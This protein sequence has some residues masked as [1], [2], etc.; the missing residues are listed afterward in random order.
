[1]IRIALDGMGGDHAPQAT[2]EGAIDASRELGTHISLVG[3][4]HILESELSRYKYNKR[5]IE[6]VPAS[7][8]I[9]MGESP[10]VVRKKKNSSINVGI[11][12]VKQ[13]KVDAFVSCG[14][15]GAVVAAAIL[16]LKSLS[17]VKRPAIATA[18][19][20]MKGMTLVIDV[21]A[22]VDPKPEH[23][24][25]Y[26]LMG[27]VYSKYILK[28]FRPTV[29]L[30]NIGE[31]ASKGNE[32]I[33][34]A[35]QLL[36]DAPINFSGNIEGRDI[37][38][39]RADVIICDGFVGNIVLKV[40]ESLAETSVEFFRREFRRSW[41]A[42][43]GALLCKPALLSLAREIDYTEFGGAPLLG[44]DGTCIIGHGASKPK[45]IKNAIRV[46]GHFVDHKVNDHIVNEL[47]NLKGETEVAEFK[48]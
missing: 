16:N 48:A 25:Q 42:R 13:K 15:T 30:L 34:E 18:L 28:K 35:Y 27:T 33:R 3:Q 11:D 12:L 47:S 44:I 6:I 2:I 43:I 26:A 1:V 38:M 45:A 36:K 5:L 40:C 8:T 46:G 29:S 19:P 37:F 41:M 20:T 31:E 7:E 23:L 22:N 14:N 32:L 17:G 39:G 21:G 24:V 9:G 10:L 4:E